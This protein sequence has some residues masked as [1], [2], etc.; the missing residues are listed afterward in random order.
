MASLVKSCAI[1][2]AASLALTACGGDS[3][4]KPV[5]E[6]P[7]PTPPVD[8]GDDQDTD[9]PDESETQAGVFLDSPVA[10]VSYTTSPSG[11]TGTTNAAGQYEYEEGDTVTFSIGGIE[12]PSV[13]AKGTVTPLDMGGDS[14]DLTTP[15][16]V[17]I[18][19]LLQTLDE[20]GDP[21]NGI[22]ITSAT[23]TALADTE[24]DFAAETF[25]T[26]ASTALTA[27]LSRSLVSAE[28][29][30]SHFEGSLK[31]QLLG[32][33]VFEEDD[34]SINVLTFF[35]EDRYVVTHSSGDDDEQTAG[36]AEYG[37]YTWNPASG[38]F[39]TELIRETDGSGGLHGEDSIKVS[40]NEDLLE[41]DF[42]DE[43]AEF[44][45]VVSETGDD[46]VGA[47]R[48]KETR[49]DEDPEGG[50]LL[51]FYTDS[52]YVFIHLYDDEE[53]PV[54]VS[55]EWST[56]EWTEDN[57][58]TV[59]EPSVETDGSAGFYAADDDDPMVLKVEGYGDFA[60]SE[61]GNTEIEHWA[62]VGRYAVP[63]QDF[64]GDTSSATIKRAYD[65]FD[66][67]TAQSFEL[68]I[69]AEGEEGSYDT[70][71]GETALVTLIADGTGTLAFADETNTISSWEVSTTGV[72]SFDEYAGDPADSA[73]WTLVPVVG[74]DGDAVLVQQSDLE[75][76]YLGSTSAATAE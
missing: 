46:L 6:I 69:L 62:R 61:V 53:D 37:S 16:V 39:V 1:I 26:E 36:S 44:Q 41:F 31:D 73:T 57:T 48:F 33:W 17:N 54:I 74:G 34:G 64:E 47:W 51:T 63:L 72:L 19:R 66:A 76:S 10:G 28:E 4:P 13:T 68:D 20:D 27:Q 58:F 9:D 50:D 23:T 24:L 75:L 70:E 8:D 29:A 30:V 21:E 56:Y 42:G 14:A 38:V 52:D 5:Q 18:I 15:T 55:S 49:P 60:L 12:L 32:S 22:T 45:R 67:E 3:D 11:Q 71:I 43:S 35:G 40:V 25:E 7:T 2:L 65:R 59:G